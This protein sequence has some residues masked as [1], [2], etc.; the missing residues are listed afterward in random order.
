MDTLTLRCPH[1]HTTNR[2]PTE[3]IDHSP[4]CG[5]CKNP[6][7]DGAPVEGTVNN[8]DAI[9]SSQ[10]T[11]VI[12]FWAP[13]CAPCQAFG[14]VF[15]DVAKNDEGKRLFVKIDTEDQQTLAAKYRIRSIPTIMI[16][17]DGKMVNHMNGALPRSQF[18]EWLTQHT[19]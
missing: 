3:R 11:I 18:E 10:K 17:K 16:F 2:I 4:L 6:L 9:M 7:V 1:C 5:A 19:S 12:D 14:P 15:E 8:I 13:W